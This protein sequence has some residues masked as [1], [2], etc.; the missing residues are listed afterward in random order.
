M[1]KNP[2]NSLSICPIK[3]DSKDLVPFFDNRISAGFPSPAEDEIEN[4]LSLNEL[5]ITHPEA[6]FF[7]K[8]DGDSMQDAHIFKE[9]IL[10]VDRSIKARHDSIILAVVKGE[11]TVK[12]LIIDGDKIFLKPEN[13]SYPCIAIENPD[14]FCVWG[15][16][17]YIIH[18]AK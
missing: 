10:I 1:S 6:T 17:T 5:L 2:S 13:P 15:C 14:D 8:V 3:I 4:K 18:K 9:D 11:F 7:I 12:R 16:V